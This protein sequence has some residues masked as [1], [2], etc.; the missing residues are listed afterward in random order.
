M[1][2][3]GYT[4]TLLVTLLLAALAQANEIRG[5]ISKVDLDKKEILL[6]GRGRGGR[7]LTLRLELDKDTRVV[8]GQTPGEPA[9]LTPGRH[10]HVS[11]EMRGEHTVALLIHALGSRPTPAIQ[12]NGDAVTGT[13][14]RVAVTDREIVVVGPGKDG[15]QTETTFAVPESTKITRGERSVS[16]EDLKEGEQVA[17]T[18]D[19][20]GNRWTATAVKVGGG[21]P[22]ANPAGAKG[23]RLGKILE[24][25]GKVLQMVGEMRRP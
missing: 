14:Q 3:N 24:V 18:G 22:P 6:E 13:L 20:H 16:L 21:A 8:F 9:D 1:R 10:V 19:K 25:V 5:V 17:V 23:E 11:Y 15:P 7:G 12:A 2:T 4:L